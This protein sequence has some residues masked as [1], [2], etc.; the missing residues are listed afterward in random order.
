MK[1]NLDFKLLLS[2][3]ILILFFVWGIFSN[4]VQKSNSSIKAISGRNPAISQTPSPTLNN[5]INPPTQGGCGCSGGSCG[6][7]SNS[8]QNSSNTDPPLQEAEKKAYEFYVQ[9]Y[10]DK[11]VVAKA[12]DFGCH[13]AVEIQ[14]DGKR[15]KSFVYKNGK[16]LE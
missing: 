3:L 10:N 9:K 11:S 8:G 14:K 7:R 2:L 16:I 5:Q 1:K 4:K 12:S 15:V 13:I 6:S